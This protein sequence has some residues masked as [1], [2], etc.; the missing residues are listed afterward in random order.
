LS[1]TRSPTGRG[2]AFRVDVSLV[3]EK[4]KPGPIKGTIRILTDDKEFPELIV[5][6]RG[7]VY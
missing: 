1:I 2:Q 3:H 4:L 7:D 5:P 6:V